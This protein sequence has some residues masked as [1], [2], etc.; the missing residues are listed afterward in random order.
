M[1]VRKFLCVL[2]LAGITL[3]F[4][5]SCNKKEEQPPDQIMASVSASAQVTQG[6]SSLSCTVVRNPEGEMCIRDRL[7]RVW[8]G[9]QCGY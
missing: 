8:S 9:L 3:L 4:M 6:E 1:N 7:D 5:V 2:V